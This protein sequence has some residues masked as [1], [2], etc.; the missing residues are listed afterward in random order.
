[1]QGLLLLINGDTAFL[2]QTGRFGW[3]AVDTSFDK[4][5]NERCASYYVTVDKES[6][7]S[8]FVRNN[9][10]IIKETDS[11]FIADLTKKI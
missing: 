9:Y 6:S 2:Y 1:M 10:K 8:K 4:L 5:I 7:D 3:P 11:F